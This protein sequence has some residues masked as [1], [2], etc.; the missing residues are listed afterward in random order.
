MV[1]I[2][3]FFFCLFP[4]QEGNTTKRKPLH[5]WI[6][7]KREREREEGCTKETGTLPR[8]KKRIKLQHRPALEDSIIVSSRIYHRRSPPSEQERLPRAVSPYMGYFRLAITA[9]KKREENASAKRLL[10]R[11][12]MSPTAHSEIS[13]FYFHNKWGQWGYLIEINDYYRDLIYLRSPFFCSGLPKKWG[14]ERFYLKN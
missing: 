7:K 4:A 1:Y 11:Q 8:E 10:L 5:S 3:F 12:F 13:I 6:N 2:I 14:L 9:K